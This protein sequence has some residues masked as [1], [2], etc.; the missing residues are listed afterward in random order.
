MTRV[1]GEAL[2]TP[3]DTSGVV[4]HL[5]AQLDL[6]APLER[7]QYS[8]AKVSARVELVLGNRN[9]DDLTGSRRRCSEV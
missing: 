4:L 7:D 1:S 5:C 8:Q 9:A 2:A 3:G 6:Q